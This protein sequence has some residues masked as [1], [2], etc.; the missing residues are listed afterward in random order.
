MARILVLDDLDDIR[1]PV[2]RRRLSEHQLTCVT[3][4]VAAMAALDVETFDV[5]HLD[6]DLGEWYKDETG[7]PRE[8]TGMTVVDHLLQQVPKERWP[9]KVIVHSWNTNRSRRMVEALNAAGI[10]AVY[11]PFTA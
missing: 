2:F 3:T 7:Q 10:H 9:S 4:A 8:R 5:L 6:H 1:H 11:Q